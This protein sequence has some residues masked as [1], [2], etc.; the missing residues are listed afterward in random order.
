M[1]IIK[2]Q[3]RRIS[4]YT[5]SLLSYSKRIPF[6]PKNV[7]L[8]EILDECIFLLGHRFR[9][10]NISIIKNYQDDLPKLNLDF[11]QMEQVFVNLLNNAVDAIKHSGEIIINVSI[12]IEN[13]SLI[14][15]STIEGLDISISDSGHGIK[16]DVIDQIFEPF[17]SSKIPTMGSGLGL[18]I[19]KAIIQRHGGKIEVTSSPG[20]GATFKIFLP[21]NFKEDM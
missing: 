21:F 2:N 15:Y 19:T 20:A 7:K 18:S 11:G 16:S 17:Y 4:K 10:H 3:T 12:V 13:S 9:A 8:N 6:N 14:N 1:N 5:R